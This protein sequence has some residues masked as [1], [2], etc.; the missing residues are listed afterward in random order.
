MVEAVA[1]DFVAA[2]M[3]LANQ[4]RITT[5]HPAEHKKC[6]LGM[7]A[8]Q[9]IEQ[10]MGAGFNPGRLMFPVGK[11]NALGRD[12][13]VEI[14]FQIDGERVAGTGAAVKGTRG[15]K[16]LAGDDGWPGERSSW[17]TARRPMGPLSTGA[18]GKRT[19]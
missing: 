7:V 4:A 3:D 18:T 11:G 19:E 9:Q 13:G 12:F 2:L 16:I 17:P 15:R 5:G 14:I 10:A 1:A 8:I 6:C